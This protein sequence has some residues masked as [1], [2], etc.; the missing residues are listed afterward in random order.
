MLMT[1]LSFIIV[2][3]ILVFFHELGHYL[4]A[5][6]SGIEVEEFGMG[7]PPRLVKLFTYDGTDFTL[8]LLTNDEVLSVNQDPRGEPAKRLV[9]DGMKEVWA[10]TMVD[11][12]RVVG[13]FN[14]SQCADRVTVQWQ[15]LG[16]T[17]PQ[18]VRD[19]WRQKDLGV[20]EGD[21]ATRVPRHGVVLIGVKKAP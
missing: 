21:F 19:L 5:R 17:G 10:K 8:N 12:S 9:R 2:L 14:R 20:F 3:G 6:R 7:Y 18:Q 15:D 1:V 16:L 13:L 11:G 4:V